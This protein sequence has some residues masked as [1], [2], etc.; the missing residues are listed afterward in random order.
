MDVLFARDILREREMSTSSSDTSSI[1]SSSIDTSSSDTSDSIEELRELHDGVSRV[2]EITVIALMKD[3]ETFLKNYLLKRLELMEDMYSSK[4]NYVFLENNSKDSTPELLKA[5]V[6]PRP[7]SEVLILD[8]PEFQ[9]LGTNFARTNRLATLRN[10]AIEAALR[11]RRLEDKSSEG[12]WFLLIDSD[13]CFDIETLSKMFDKKPALNNVGML[14]AFT[15]EA[16]FG[17]QVNMHEQFKH[18]KDDEVMTFNHY[19]DTFALVTLDSKNIR[20]KCPFKTCKMCGV[21]T[22]DKDGHANGLLD[23]KSCYNGFSIVDGKVLENARVRWGTVDIEGRTSLCE[24]VLFC[25][26]LR[27]AT[28]KRVCIATD[29][30]QV[31]WTNP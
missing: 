19:A 20:P 31:F 18:F 13:I 5:F 4:F 14:S 10:A 29:V 21:S 1:D 23:V 2:G 12:H 6:E 24:H 26:S 27:A 22:H 17:R 15:I 9:N 11:S 28:G 8:L 30:D 16:L 25:H 7:G 3:N